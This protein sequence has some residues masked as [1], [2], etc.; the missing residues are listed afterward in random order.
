MIALAELQSECDALEL[1]KKLNKTRYP[2]LTH[3]RKAFAQWG[4]K[5]LKTAAAT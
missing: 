4:Q 5:Y 1:E 3:E 2:Y